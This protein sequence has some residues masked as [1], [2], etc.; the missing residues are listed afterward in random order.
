MFNPLS[1]FGV[2]TI[3][4]NRNQ[5]TMYGTT[6]T[7]SQTITGC[8][9]VEENHLVRDSNGHEVVSSTQVAIPLD[10]TITADEEATVTLPSGRTARVLS[11]ATADPAGLPLPGFKQLNLD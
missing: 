6:T 11:V 8:F 3:T 9:V 1:V 2:H 10:V 7:T 4:L 5:A